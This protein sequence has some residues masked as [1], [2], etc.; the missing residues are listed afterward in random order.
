MAQPNCN[1]AT[2][3]QT[4]FQ[5]FLMSQSNLLSVMNRFFF[6]SIDGLWFIDKRL[7]FLFST[8]HNWIDEISAVSLKNYFEI[9][10]LTIQML[11]EMCWLW[12]VFA[13][14]ATSSE[15]FP[16]IFLYWKNWN[17]AFQNGASSP[18]SHEFTMFPIFI[19]A[20]DIS[21]ISALVGHWLQLTIYE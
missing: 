15:R 4:P 12:L 6:V 11:A 3:S 19:F 1:N 5:A 17:S 20:K 14:D 10:R 13:T 8:A 9:F 2:L 18:Y 7:F 21:K 16:L